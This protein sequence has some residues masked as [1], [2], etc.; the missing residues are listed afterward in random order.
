MICDCSVSDNKTKTKLKTKKIHLKHTDLGLNFFLTMPFIQYI[1]V[2]INF[3][4][5]KIN[6]IFYFCY[7]SIVLY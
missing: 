1:I 5:S 3:P 4:I 6:G 2:K 7:L